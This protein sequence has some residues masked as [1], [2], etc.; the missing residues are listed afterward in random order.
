[1][2]H[3]VIIGNGISG[4]TCARHLRKLSDH[5]ITVISSESEF[6]FSRTALMYIF[7]GHMRFQ[8][9]KPYEDFFWKKN[10]IELKK[11]HVNKIDSGNKS[12]LL[13]DGTSMNYDQLVIACGSRP[14]MGDWPGKHFEGVQGLVSLQDLEKLEKNVE[15]CKRALVIG[16]G[17]IGVELAEMLRSRNIEVIYAVREFKF[18]NRVL[19]FEESGMIESHI[20]RD[21]N[22]DLK[23]GVE[24]KEIKGNHNGRVSSVVLSNGEELD[25]D[26]VGVTIGVT[27]NIHFLANSGIETQKGILVNEFLE[28]NIPDVFALGDCAEFREALPGRLKLEQIWYTGRMQ[29][30]SLAR[31]LAGKRTV[32]KPVNFFNSAKLFD[33]EFQVYS[34]D[35]II[36]NSCKEIFW[37]SND[38]MRSIRIYFNPQTLLFEGVTLL[39]VRYRHE[40]CDRW[41]RENRDVEYV[42]EHLADANFDPEFFERNEI[43]LIAVYNKTYK[44]NL[45]LKKK[46]WTRIFGY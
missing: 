6:F 22:I 38:Y 28:T 18:W 45:K 29:A 10:R 2:K 24:L 15:N 44:K 34:R 26:F 23:L 33:I 5:R 46:S 42:L 32:Y 43:D 25:C 30:E 8:D 19:P 35:V 20:I 31:T 17:L 11:A 16:G 41:L 7:M 13:D 39:G 27:P 12:L 40:V 9:T 36:D 1:M 37:R 14:V 3:T 21:H 4:I